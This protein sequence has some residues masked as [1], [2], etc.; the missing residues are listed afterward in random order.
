[1]LPQTSA[2]VAER[3]VIAVA[4]VLASPRFA[5]PLSECSLV[6]VRTTVRTKTPEKLVNSGLGR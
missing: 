3:I 6:P 2:D 4:K 5:G 1:L